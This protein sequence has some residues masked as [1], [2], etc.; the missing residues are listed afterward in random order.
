MQNYKIIVSLKALN[1]KEFKKFGEYVNSPYYNKNVHVR[2]LY[3][4]LSKYHPEFDNKNLS[5]ESI[6]SKVFPKEKYDY[7]KINNIISDLYKLFESYLFT[8]GFEKEKQFSKHILLRELSNRNLSDVYEK[9]ESNYKKELSGLKVIDENYYFHLYKLYIESLN[10]NISKKPTDYPLIIQN[11]FDSFL[12]YAVVSLL[13]LYMYMHHLKK[14]NKFDFNMVMFENFSAFVKENDFEDNPSYMVYKGIMMLEIYKEKEYFIKLKE[15]K[16]KY[17]QKISSEDLQNVLIFMV[18][19]CADAINK[20]DD[21]DFYREEFEVVKEIVERKIYNIDNII[22][23]NLINIYKSACVVGE[24]EWSEKFLKEFDKSI[25]AKDRDNVLNFCYGYMN[26]RKRNFEKSLEFFAKTNFQWFILKMFVKT[27]TLRIYYETEMYEQAFAFIDTYKHYI[28]YDDKLLDEHR[29]AHN[30]F[31][32]YTTSLIKLKMDN[33]YKTK[34]FELKDLKNKIE[35]MET[36][37]FGTKRWLMK[38][39]NELEGK[40]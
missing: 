20:Y 26:Y 9:Q 12:H 17:V 23:P 21:E 11:E 16:N 39:V 10:Y 36:N 22:Y 18:A 32:K 19:Y 7:F 31:L 8:I 40:P 33:S 1:K 14:Q 13:K 38:K 15:I 3:D 5:I 24:Y 6:F 27:M 28:Q 25:P 37:S 29:T 35:K 30:L 34:P 2:K 4:S